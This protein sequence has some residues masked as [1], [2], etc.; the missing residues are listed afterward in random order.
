MNCHVFCNIT[1]EELK[2]GDNNIYM[3]FFFE[4]LMCRVK[5]KGEGIPKVKGI[6]QAR[7]QILHGILEMSVILG[8]WMLLST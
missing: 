4:N 3:L 1:F 8:Q 7:S 5:P 2:L 6:G